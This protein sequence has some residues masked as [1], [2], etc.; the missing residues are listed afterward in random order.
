MFSRGQVKSHLNTKKHKLALLRQNRSL[1]KHREATASGLAEDVSRFSS[2]FLDLAA[3][4]P[5]HNLFHDARL[6]DNTWI[7]EQGNESR[8]PATVREDQS[9]TSQRALDFWRDIDAGRSQNVPTDDLWGFSSDGNDDDKDNNDNNDDGQG[10]SDLS[11]CGVKAHEMPGVSISE[12]ES[13][14]FRPYASKT[15][16]GL[17]FLPKENG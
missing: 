9:W 16:G 12:S 5:P 6:I 15:V 2:P 7:D 13:D 14:G 10:D 8:L 1:G 3:T 4:Q 17:P 11:N